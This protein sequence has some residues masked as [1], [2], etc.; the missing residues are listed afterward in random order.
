[1]IRINYP[2][3]QLKNHRIYKGLWGIY[4]NNHDTS[5]KDFF[6]AL[7]N[8]QRKSSITWRIRLETMSKG[9]GLS[10]QCSSESYVKKLNEKG[11]CYKDVYS[12]PIKSKKTPPHNWGWYNGEDT[13]GCVRRCRSCLNCQV[14]NFRR[15]PFCQ[16]YAG[17]KY[18]KIR[19]SKFDI[20]Q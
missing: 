4:W 2:A 12:W 10:D 19:L 18:G 6:I 16:Y 7:N 8:Y 5:W 9:F 3:F 11:R 17:F 15:F 20:D 1:M 14:N 13:Q